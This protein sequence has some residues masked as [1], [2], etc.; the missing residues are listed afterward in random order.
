MERGGFERVLVRRVLACASQPDKTCSNN[1]HIT[2]SNNDGS[3]FFNNSGG[4]FPVKRKAVIPVDSDA[5]LHSVARRHAKQKSSRI[6]SIPVRSSHSTTFASFCFAVQYG[7]P[8]TDVRSDNQSFGLCVNH[9]GCSA[10]CYLMP[11]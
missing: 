10:Y 5:S 1:K 2:Q 4:K 11:V 8:C 7:F 9:S 3:K 6:V